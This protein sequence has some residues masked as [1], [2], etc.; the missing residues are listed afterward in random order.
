MSAAIRIEIASM[1]SAETVHRFRNLGE[2]ICRQLQDRCTVDL[3]EIDAA[4]TSFIVRDIRTQDLGAVTQL[5]KK[6]LKHH[7][8]ERTA[9]VVRI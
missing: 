7:H 2:E 8:F 3:A 1:P 9:R 5:I 4:T 6:R